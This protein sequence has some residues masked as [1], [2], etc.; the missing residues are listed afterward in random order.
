ML[1]ICNICEWS[2]ICYTCDLYTFAYNDWRRQKNGVCDIQFTVNLAVHFRLHLSIR[3]ITITLRFECCLYIIYALCA[4]C[5]PLYPY[6]SIQLSPDWAAIGAN[7]IMAML[8]LAV[9]KVYTPIA[10]PKNWTQTYTYTREKHE[11]KETHTPK[12]TNDDDGSAQRVPSSSSPP[13]QKNVH[14]PIHHP[15]EPTEPSATS[16]CRSQRA[17]PRAADSWSSSRE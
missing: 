9:R 14:H 8:H 10:Q 3:Y 7:F 4:L 16:F 13:P 15:T 6:S 17:A 5:C 2:E 1:Y 11:K 12:T